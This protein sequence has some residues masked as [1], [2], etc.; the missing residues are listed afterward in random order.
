MAPLMEAACF[1]FENHLL[2]KYAG[3]PCDIWIGRE[4][5]YLELLR[6]RPSWQNSW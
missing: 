1:V 2:A 4:G 5:A 3:P 6:E